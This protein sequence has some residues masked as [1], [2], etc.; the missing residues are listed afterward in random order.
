MMDHRRILGA[1]AASLMLALLVP[2]AGQAAASH[3]ART[4]SHAKVIRNNWGP[5]LTAVRRYAQRHHIKRVRV[6]TSIYKRNGR[7]HFRTK[8][9]HLHGSARHSGRSS[10][11]MSRAFTG[12]VT[13]GPPI[14]SIQTGFSCSVPVDGPT[15]ETTNDSVSF[16]NSQ[17][18]FNSLTQNCSGHDNSINSNSTATDCTT[19]SGGDPISSTGLYTTFADGEYTDYC[20]DPSVGA[21]YFIF[22]YAPIGNA[23]PVN[24]GFRCEATVGVGSDGNKAENVYTS[25]SVEGSAPYVAYELFYPLGFYT[26]LTTSCVGSVLA[27][28]T[29]PSTPVAHTVACMQ[30]GDPSV[31]TAPVQGYGVSVTYPDGQ[32]SETCNTPDYDALFLP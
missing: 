29:V 30:L 3:R 21:D 6:I 26:S 4:V 14:S 25:D 23:S 11:K 7:L 18:G 9:A 15:A 22:G 16:Y 1:L 5:V 27:G 19:Y 17:G 32:Y 8:L 20:N 2:A 31:S 10:L 12:S 28:V 24:Q 13:A